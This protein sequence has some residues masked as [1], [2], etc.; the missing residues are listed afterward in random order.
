MQF[1]LLDFLINLNIMIMILIFFYLQISY[2]WY[3]AIGCVLT[4][5]L[6]L[7]VSFITG[8]QNPA[9]VDQ[10]FLSPPIAAMFRMQTKPQASTNVQ[11]IA[12][13]GLELEDEKPRQIDTCKSPKCP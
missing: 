8:A 1:F 10:D 3:S 2:L 4:I 6:G 11:G 5:L 12:N 9:D 7:T 13:L